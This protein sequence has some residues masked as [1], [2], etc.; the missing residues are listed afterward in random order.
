MRVST[1]WLSDY[2]S[3]P[4]TAKLA[5]RLT[6]T[7]TEV[8]DVV[9]VSHL[10]RVRV[11]EVVELTAHPDADA[12][13]V[14]KV[15]VGRSVYTIICG[16]SNVAEGIKVA[17]ALPGTTLPDGMKIERRKIRGIES[18]G[19]I[20][21]PRELG[22]G[23]D[24][25]GIW[26]LP[27][28]AKSGA[29]LSEVTTLLDSFE[30]DVLA[31]RPDC[32]G[33]IGIAREVAAATGRKLREPKL[34]T[35][36]RQKPGPYRVS[37]DRDLC[38]R[39]GIALLE[40]I[41][42]TSSPAWLQD[43][44]RAAGMRPISLVV[45]VTNFV[46]LE[47]G[48]PL[49]GFDAHSMPARDIAVRKARTG[50][51]L[52]LLN[53]ETKILTKE[54]PVITAGGKAIALAGIMGGHATEVSEETTSVLLEAAHFNQAFTRRASRR[55]GLRTEASARFEKGV[56]SAVV[57]SA[58]RR[59]V[60]LIN[61]YGNAQLVQFSITG[62]DTAPRRIVLRDGHVSGLL[63][64][65][66]PQARSSK[67]LRAVGCAVSGRK[68]LSVTPPNWRM[69]LVRAEDLIEEVARLEGYDTF[70]STMPTV[71]THSVTIP[72]EI[73]VARRIAE[74]L[75]GAGVTEVMTHSLVG[76]AL[77]EKSGSNASDAPQIANPLSGD[78]AFLRTDMLPRHL[79]SIKENIKEF[80]EL[81]WFESGVI[82]AK[83][84]SKKVPTERDVVAITLASLR[85]KELLPRLRG[86]LEA[87]LTS[88][89]RSGDELVFSDVPDGR[90]RVGRR[91]ALSIDNKLLGVIGDI[92][93]PNAWK[94]G[95]IVHMALSLETLALLERSAS[96]TPPPAYPPVRRDISVSVPA[97]STY[98]DLAGLIRA[99]C[100]TALRSVTEPNEYISGTG[101]SISVRL[102][103][104]RSE[105]TMT[106]EEVARLM[107][108]LATT[109]TQRGYAL[110]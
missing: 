110:R 75:R 36:L 82:F 81:N 32:L 50:E 7:L 9:S 3:L 77:L 56:S 92:A 34:V 26:V 29:R 35:P 73:E 45:D 87:L 46:M 11:G 96:V 102:D 101:R 25:S 6:M 79:E 58:L 37:L 19:M 14:C 41:S 71:N 74:V 48:Q 15:A 59:A 61:K 2:V 98:A 1:R 109:L 22:I 51:K 52:G 31:N 76:E 44:I 23:E 38:D 55:L 104:G 54:I 24:H 94:A 65:N 60:D 63:G 42:N 83:S 27:S 99:T 12:L 21:S 85:K 33:Y 67:H 86:I 17:V 18:E 78:H 30:L 80:Q 64:K 68:D 100:G 103:F 66:I 91:S 39:Y 97:G 20:C 106:D 95:S 107:K 13:S 53:G 84:K 88:L 28:D 40:G 16:A 69:D 105:S 8:E 62:K 89:G 5:E 108:R 43:R 57:T 70:M 10:K 90:L 4:E 49:H 72:R 47:Y 93:S